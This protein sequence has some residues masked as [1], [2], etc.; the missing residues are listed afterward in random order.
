MSEFQA[1]TLYVCP[2]L[3]AWNSHPKCD[4]W[5]SIFLGDF[6][7]ESSQNISETTPR[8]LLLIW[9]SSTHK[10]KLVV[11]L[12]MSRKWLHSTWSTSV[13]VPEIATRVACPNSAPDNHWPAVC[14]LD[15][16]IKTHHLVLTLRQLLDGEMGIFGKY[17]LKRIQIK[18]SAAN[19]VTLR[20]EGK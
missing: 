8:S 19:D 20:D 11:N 18:D 12:Q 16:P 6:F 17:G 1:E 14:W 5:H 3:S 9:G 4:F 10:H 13:V 7:F 15:S 2:K